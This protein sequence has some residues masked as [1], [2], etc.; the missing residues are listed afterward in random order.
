MGSMTSKFCGDT[1]SG[2][3]LGTLSYQTLRACTFVTVV[4][5][6]SLGLVLAEAPA[7]RAW[8]S[9]AC[10]TPTGVTVVVDFGE[11]GGGT[12]IRCAAG[13]QSSGIA[14]L[15]NAG[16]SVGFVQRNSAQGLF[17]CRIS[18]KPGFDKATCADTPPANFS[19]S[20]WNAQR[21]G[22]WHYSNA[23]AGNRTPPAGSV[24]GWRFNAGRPT[25]PT[26]EPPAV[27]VEPI[28]I[29]KPTRDPI[30]KP[31]AKPTHQPSA[32]ASESTSEQVRAAGSDNGHARAKVGAPESSTGMNAAAGQQQL[33]TV[34]DDDQVRA[35]QSVAD[36]PKQRGPLELVIAL[37]VV[38]LLGGGVVFVWIRRSNES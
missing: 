22:S 8:S 38:G 12:E 15:Q 11:L 13:P 19:W 20:Y 35:V 27:L 21:G 28:P 7:A 10:P 2:F 34:V 24:E 37:L 29:D 16:Y 25:W 23:G 33:G 26:V 1:P 3:R 17:V 6:L 32:I 31:T 9:G 30:R 36:L 14:A 18:G 4:A 5:V